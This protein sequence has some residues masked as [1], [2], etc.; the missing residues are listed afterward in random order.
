MT[1]DRRAFL[2][3]VSA[4]IAGFTALG[5]LPLAAQTAARTK[6]SRK[7]VVRADDIGMSRFCNI[8]SFEAIENGVVT[9]ADVMLDSPGTEDALE[10]LKKFPWISIGWHTHMWGAPVVESWRVPSLVEKTGEFAGRFRTDLA[11]TQDVVFEEALFELRAQLERCVKILGKAP[12]TGGGGRGNGPWGRAMSQVTAE[13]GLV[14]NF[15]VPA[16]PNKKFEAFR[17]KYLKR[18]RDAQ[19]AGEEWAKYYNVNIPGA[20]GA[21]AQSG[22]SGPGRGAAAAQGAPGVGADPRFASR[23]II[24]PVGTFAYVDLLTDSISKVEREYDPVLFYTEDRAG[25]L[26][27]PDDMIFAQ[28]WH[29]GY[30]DYYTYRLGE[31]ANRAR[32]QQFVVGRTQDVAAMCDPRLKNWIRQNRIE[33]VNFRDALYGTDDYQNH[34]RTVGSDL[35]MRA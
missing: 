10:R 13:F 30:V 2:R 29:P 20:G 33:L 11:Q 17:D 26:D 8:G 35:Y 1:H 7:I 27:Y 34:L 15:T 18:I 19:Q 31:R 25:I 22:A 28:A 23:K 9:A 3:T 6:L 32:A 14:A 12:D 24:M 4:G 5:A 21:P 16:P